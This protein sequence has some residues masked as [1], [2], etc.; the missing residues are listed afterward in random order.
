[1]DRKKHSN[2]AMTSSQSITEPINELISQS[3]E[4]LLSQAKLYWFYG[5]WDAIVDID[6]SEVE[7]N[8]NQAEIILLLA[9]AHQ[10]LGNFELAEQYTRQAISLGCDTRTV[11]KLC[12]AG[13]YNILG[14]IAAIQND[15]EK[16]ESAFLESVDIG[17]RKD[18]ELI[19]H[20]RAVRE[21]AKLGLLPQAA[22][23]IDIKLKAV[24]N[25]P[26]KIKNLSAQTKVLETELGL[27]SHELNIS[28]QRNQL[29]R[30]ENRQSLLLE[31]ELEIGS[32][33][34]IERLKQVS[35]SQL[36]QDLWVLEKTAYKRNGFFVEFGAT[37]GV[38]LSNSF[39]LEKEFGWQGICAEPNPKFFEQLKQNRNCIV[40]SACISGKTGE[41]VKF[42]FAQEYGSMQKH[43]ADDMHKDKRQAYLDQGSEMLLETISLNDFLIANNAPKKIDYLSI[44]TEGSEFEIL[45]EFPLDKW[46]IQLLSIEH[47]FSAIRDDIYHHLI[48]YGYS[49]IEAKWDDFYEKVSNR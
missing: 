1:M 36:G 21:M 9:S 6:Y 15:Q 11:G 4:S 43:M 2:K 40:S 13:A 49:R 24:I 23:L 14:R 27:L 46:N 3:E 5:D 17:N 33:E 20:S 28:L 45:K 30:E 22:K 19:A 26:S 29:Y 18:L 44:D 7:K 10:Q 25:S 16:I 8:S 42:V 41:K 12:I 39:L 47:N 35:T 34:Y 31:S 32:P 37:D 38:L 48:K